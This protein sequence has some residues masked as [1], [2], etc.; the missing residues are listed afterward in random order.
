MADTPQNGEH[1]S[2]TL[3]DEVVQKLLQVIDRPEKFAEMFCSVAETQVSVRK[4][5]IDI[6]KEAVKTDTE[7]REA[8]KVILKE[9]YADDFKYWF[10]S[11]WGKIAIGLWTLLVV[12]ATA[13]ATNFLGK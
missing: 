4:K 6:L 5:L 9:I 7:A 2:G 11:V 1:I 10:R 13:W 12:V 3:G 8:M